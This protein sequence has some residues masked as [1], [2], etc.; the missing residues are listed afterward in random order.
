MRTVYYWGNPQEFAVARA[1]A[2]EDGVENIKG[3]TRDASVFSGDPEPC[4]KCVILSYVHPVF[5]ARI[6]A[7]YSTAGVPVERRAVE[8]PELDTPEKAKARADTLASEQLSAQRVSKHMRRM[9]TRDLREMAKERGVDVSNLRDRMQIIA[10]I[11]AKG[12]LT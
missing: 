5:A 3:I 1:L 12:K 2:A 6:D 7:A 4:A 9:H 10:A 11:Q 8:L